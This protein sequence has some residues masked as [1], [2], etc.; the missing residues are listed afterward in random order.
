MKPETIDRLA[1]SIVFLLVFAMVAIFSI[2]GWA[3]IEIVLW[4]TS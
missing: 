4:L 3:F 2:L 1:W